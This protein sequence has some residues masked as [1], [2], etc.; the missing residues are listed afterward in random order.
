[1]RKTALLILVLAGFLLNIKTAR[2]VTVVPEIEP[3]EEASA[4]AAPLV[5]PTI[6]R[7][8]I[9]EPTNQETIYRLES[10]LEG[11]REQ[12]W[13]GWNTARKVVAA[14]V[15]R[16]VSANT[17]VLLLMLP[18]VATLISVLHYVLGL[19]GY[20]IFMPTM[21]AVTF[22]ATGILGGLAMFG[23]TLAVSM[24]GGTVLKKFRLHFWPAR[25]IGLMLIALMTFGLMVGSSF[26]K[27]IDISRISIFPVLFM[28]L[29]TEE[30]VRT[31]MA[32]SK[33]EAKRLTVGTL[34]LAVTGAVLMSVRMV[35]EIVLLNPGI[36]ILVVVAVNLLVGNYKGIR[37][38]EI[39]RF[40][41]A[42]R[43]KSSLKK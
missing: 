29:L 6:V 16:G 11:Q 41:A 7:E 4:S 36:T 26:I 19:S 2:A 20:G 23:V 15:D 31:Q 28:V 12:K 8:N 34:V 37:L 42:I 17:I 33:S 24:W 22:L 43:A 10:V 32:K 40:K 39:S 21:I 18:L 1:M 14:A 13:N 25:A 35:Q 30:F 5:V 27:V 3:T 9:T 38:T